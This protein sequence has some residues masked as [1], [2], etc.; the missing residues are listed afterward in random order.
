MSTRLFRPRALRRISSPEQL[1]RLV[2][3]TSPR[4]WIGLGGLLLVV[5]VVVVWAAVSAVPTTLSGP[6]YLL[7]L[8]GL[9]E[10]Q[11]P[12]SGTISSVSVALGSHVVARQPLATIAGPGGGSTVV[13]APEAGTITESDVVE[14]SVVEFGQRLGLLEPAGW[15][16]VVYAYVPTQTAAALAPGTPVQV[17]FGAGIGSA[18]GYAKGHVAFVS[19]FATTVEQLSF[20]LQS[21][22][23]V[24]AV[25]ALG[26]TN[27]VVISLDLSARTPSWLS[28]G[29][30]SGP[31]GVL[32]NGLPARVTFIVGS[33]HPIDDFL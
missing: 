33:H 23:V 21:G 19:K 17:S 15:P 18:Y 27:E 20:I 29:S 8:N 9:R 4:R 12:A 3:V 22:E 28:W 2:H 25:Q 5:V 31:P 32:P 13:R 6:G 30:G 10:V 7:P 1:D 16:P 11:S 14:H 26:P 24:K